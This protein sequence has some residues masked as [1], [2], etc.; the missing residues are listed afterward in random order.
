MAASGENILQV[1]D[2]QVS[3]GTYAGRFRRCGGFRST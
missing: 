3:F 2:L 1:K